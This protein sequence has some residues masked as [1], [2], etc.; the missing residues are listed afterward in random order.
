MQVAA[1]QQFLRSLV[2]ALEAAGDGRA[3]GVAEEAARA[4]DPFRSL[5]LAEFAVFLSR[6][7]EYR[8]TGAVRAPGAADIRAEGL[9]T[10][11]ARLT[12]AT[13]GDRPTA[14][15]LAAA[16]AE[17]AR[18]VGVLARDAGLRGSLAPDP[19]WAEAEAARA[20]VAPHLRAVRT[21]AARI[22]SPDAYADPAVRDDIARLESALDPATLKAVGAE[23]G[24]AVTARSSPPK[25]VGDILTRLSGH[26]APKGR[27]GGRSKPAVAPDPA[28]V[29]EH[30]TR[31]ATLVSRSADPAA[32][33]EAEVEAEL[34]RLKGLPKP[35][36]VE[37]VTRA[38]IEGVKPRD[39]L[40]AIHQRVRNR[41]T[42]A[43]RARDRAEV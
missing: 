11:V 32:V 41:L 39:A 18:N 15:D 36:L 4:L 27:A 35:A 17:V 22:T 21:L 29:E 34:A 12:A 14:A 37:V 38:G 24:V 8:R 13:A 3:A 30:A 23:F 20:R 10:A 6:A 33:P 31:L 40:S 16:Q 43:R 28:L 26:A 25:V 2:P 5:A 7:E 42:A 9:L 19:K 1:L